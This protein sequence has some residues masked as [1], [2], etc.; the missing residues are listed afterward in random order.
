MDEKTF[1]GRC[2][3]MVLQHNFNTSQYKKIKRVLKLKINIP[4]LENEHLVIKKD[5]ERVY[6][7]L[8][9][10]IKTI[11]I[12]LIDNLIKSCR[13]S[14]VSMENEVLRQLKIIDRKKQE[15]IHINYE[16]LNHE[17]LI[18][19]I[20]S[21][22]ENGTFRNGILTG[23]NNI[24]VT[25][26]FKSYIG[27]K[28]INNITLEMF[29]TKPIY[30]SSGRESYKRLQ[31]QEYYKHRYGMFDFECILLK[32]PQPLKIYFLNHSWSDINNSFMQCYSERI[33]KIRG[34]EPDTLKLRH[35]K[36][37]FNCI[38]GLLNPEYPRNSHGAVVVY[39]QG[40]IEL[41]MLYEKTTKEFKESM[42]DI[43][44]YYKIDENLF[45]NILKT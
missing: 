39:R 14:F 27:V 34:N 3:E 4:T 35:I 43:F 33:D 25:E 13:K 26:Q 36:S 11:N 1:F 6:N 17:K 8:E 38:D 18:K 16:K 24:D 7:W 44:D 42:I 20:E 29:K 28:L 21:I 37:V 31:I 22:V 41:N 19:L 32:Y 10:N 2:K 5:Y 15:A 9:K 40:L 45:Y 30:Y 12:L 23:F